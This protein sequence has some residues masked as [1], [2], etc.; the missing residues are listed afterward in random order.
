VS[1]FK[2]TTLAQDTFGLQVFGDL[3]CFLRFILLFLHY[4][5]GA[6]CLPVVRSGILRLAVCWS[7]QT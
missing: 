4:S 5:H 1:K 2:D 6:A 7:D 3:E